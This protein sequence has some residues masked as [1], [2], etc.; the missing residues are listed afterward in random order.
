MNRALKT[1]WTG[2]GLA[3]AGV[4]ALPIG[5]AF[6]IDRPMANN[7]M[8]ES[9]TAQLLA[10]GGGGGSRSGEAVPSRWQWRW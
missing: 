3:L 1:A 9:G 4:L 7:P 8:P 2:L 5:T 6:A 10:R